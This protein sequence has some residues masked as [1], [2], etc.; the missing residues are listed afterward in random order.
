MTRDAPVHMR[1]SP[2]STVPQSCDR[3]SAR[4]RRGGCR[5]RAFLLLDDLITAEYRAATP[6]PSTNPAGMR[7]SRRS[8]VV[9]EIILNRAA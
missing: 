1:P 2:A 5:P 7:R 8:T 4:Q 9:A 6:T 3:G